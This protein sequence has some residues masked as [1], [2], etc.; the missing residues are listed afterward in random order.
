MAYWNNVELI[1]FIIKFSVALAALVYGSITDL[2]TR[3]VPD[4]INYG[5]IVSGVGLNAIFSA[6]LSDWSHIIHSFAGLGIFFAIGWFMFY[7]GQW[8]GGDSKMLMG[9]GAMIGIDV[10]FREPQFLAGFLINAMFVGAL[11]GLF[12]SIFLAAKNHAKFGRNFSRILKE[13]KIVLAKK[14]LL[15]L[16]VLLFVLFFMTEDKYKKISL[17]GLD[18]VL[19]MSFYLWVSIK[20]V[21]KI[22]M[23]KYVEPMKLTEGDWIVN[24]VYYRKERIVGPKDLGIEKRQIKILIDLYKKGKI[25][26]VLIKEGIPFVPSFLLSFLTTLAFGN[27]LW[28]VL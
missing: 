3:E 6:A 7:F 19:I 10:N 5:L 20:A 15:C 11:Y 21:E 22:S 4:W 27:L 25:K 26:K 18:I 12:W 14:I 9:L 24:D 1:P 16:V 28:M 13:K 23:L 17:I 8:G 2:K